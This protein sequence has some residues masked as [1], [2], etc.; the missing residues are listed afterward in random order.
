MLLAVALAAATT[1]IDASDLQCGLFICI[2]LAISVLFQ[3]AV[4]TIND[5]FDYVKGTDTVENQDD[6]TDA[7][8]VYNNVNPRHALA[9]AIALI[10][11]A[12]ALG[13]FCILR[14]G[15]IPLVVAVVGVVIVFLYSGGRT[16]I[17]Y[18][19]IGELVSGFTMGGLITLASYQV[20]TLNFEWLVLL[21]ALPE[22]LGIA[23]IMMTNNGC[24]RAKDDQAHR[25]TLPVLLGYERTRKV[26]HGIIYAWMVAICALVLLFFPK[27][28]VVLPFMLLAVHPLGRALLANP[29]NPKSR[30]AAFAQCTSLNV[31]L[32][33]FY[34]AAVF[35]SAVG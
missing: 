20:I 2:L 11:C 9:F 10:L 22:I 28:W 34:A 12:F 3:S 35:A 33:A 7:V 26:Y 16:P 31:A 21:W 19:P 25:R 5:Y 4:N 29:L 8:L 13:V 32:G 18:L 27:G 1:G 30:G 15:W 6:P 24:D 23:L 17:S 14:A